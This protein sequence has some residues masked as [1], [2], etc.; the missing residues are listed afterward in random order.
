[1]SSFRGV[2]GKDRKFA[3]HESRQTIDGGPHDTV[4][5]VGVTRRHPSKRTLWPR[6]SHAHGQL[7]PCVSLLGL[8][9]ARPIIGIA[10]EREHMD[11]DSQK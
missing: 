3:G 2:R 10:V 6:T 5:S 9:L 1:M 4:F 11:L 8:Y 7:H